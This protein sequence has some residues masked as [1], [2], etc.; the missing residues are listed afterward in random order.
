MR[1]RGTHQKGN[2]S[3]SEEFELEAQ[4]NYCFSR[5]YGLIIVHNQKHMVK[6]DSIKLFYTNGQA[7]NKHEIQLTERTENVAYMA[8]LTTP[9]AKFYEFCLK[10][11]TDRNILQNEFHFAG[12]YSL[13][14]IPDTFI[15]NFKVSVSF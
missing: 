11:L 5:N 14:S 15:S 1:N 3:V 10:G 6:F 8:R 12:K 13:I 4:G 9:T 2:N 7:K